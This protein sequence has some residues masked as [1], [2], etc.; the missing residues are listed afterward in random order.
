[1][2]TDQYPTGKYAKGDETRVAHSRGQAVE[3]VWDG[4]R[5]VREEVV[6][7]ALAEPEPFVTDDEYDDEEPE[8]TSE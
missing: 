7:A 6:Q 8:P 3:F 4:F 2:A 1:M 5:P